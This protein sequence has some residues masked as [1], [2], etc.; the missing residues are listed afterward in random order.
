MF[1]TE[2]ILFLQ[3][4]ASGWLT[5]AMAT[6]TSMGYVPFYVVV[7][8]GIMLGLDLR[9]GFVLAQ[10][11][12]WTNLVTDIAKWCFA[13]PRPTDVDAAVIDPR[14][15]TANPTPW[16]SRGATGFLALPDA[17]AIASFRAQP[18][19]SFGF[20]SGHVSTTVA[21]WGGLTVVFARRFLLVCTLVAAPLMALSRMY[22]GRHFLADVLGGAALGGLVVVMARALLAGERAPLPLLRLTDLASLATP[23]RLAV[24]AWLV[25]APLALTTLGGIIDRQRIGQL[26]GLN[27]AYLALAARG[28]PN[29]APGWPRALARVALGAVIG[30]LAAIGVGLAAGLGLPGGGTAVGRIASGMPPA[31]LLL[32]GTVTLGRRLGLYRAD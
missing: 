7:I 4:L 26:L 11:V 8:G 24:A 12:I 29:A 25:A 32:W 23:R 13:L 20:P 15:G 21:L 3:A 1:Q 16:L 31:F 22:L 10:V 18:S 6:V 27:L 17:E 5:W 14:R 28:L 30:S 2:P 9:R 19:R